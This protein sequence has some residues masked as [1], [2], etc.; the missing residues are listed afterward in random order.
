MFI[1][2]SIRKGRVRVA[3]AP[4]KSLKKINC[5]KKDQDEMEEEE[6]QE[7]QDQKQQLQQLQ[8]QRQQKKNKAK[9]GRTIQTE[10][11]NL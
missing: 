1:V 2:R 4:P 6:E 11:G 8:R 7:E 5:E 3:E 10:T 9:A